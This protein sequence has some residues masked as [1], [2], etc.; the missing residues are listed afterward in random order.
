MF[1]VLWRFPLWGSG[2][3]EQ[4]PPPGP[5]YGESWA[6]PVNAIGQRVPYNQSH[7][8]VDWVEMGHKRTP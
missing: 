7:D 3:T 4:A 8:P 2:S 5:V 1:R 6:F